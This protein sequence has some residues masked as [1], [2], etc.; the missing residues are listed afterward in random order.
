LGRQG[1]VEPPRTPERWFQ[2][3]TEKNLRRGIFGSVP[4][5]VATIESY[6]EAN[7]DIPKPHVW[8]ATAEDIL[9]KVARAR[10]VL[11]QV[12]S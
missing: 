4:D 1:R 10:A 6:L 8:T 12:V 2:D 11:N 7:N 9:T 3:L 5:L